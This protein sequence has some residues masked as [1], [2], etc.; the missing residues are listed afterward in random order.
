MDYK[1]KHLTELLE[2]R[3]HE[4]NG[5]TFIDEPTAGHFVSYRQLYEKASSTLFFLQTH[6][7]KPGDLL[8]FQLS[9]HLDFLSAFWACLLGKIIPAAI[10]VGPHPVSI[11]KLFK[12]WQLLPN[13]HLITFKSRLD[14]LQT[15]AEER[16]LTEIF[17][18]MKNRSI[19]IQEINESNN[20]TPGTISIPHESDPAF[21]QFSSGST[22]DPKGIILTHRNLIVNIAAII[23]GLKSPGT[24]KCFSWMP[25]SHDMGLIGFHLVPLA[26]NWDH[27]LMA[28]QLFVRNPGLWLQKISET[29]STLTV[30]PNFGY[31]YTLKHYSPA[32][33]SNLDLSC[34][35][36]I[37]NG[38]EPISPDVC[39]EFT[40]RFSRF[41]LKPQSMFPVYGLAE[42]SLAVTF[43]EPGH[44]PVFHYFKRDSLTLGKKAGE[45]GNNENED[46]I[47]LMEVGKPVNDCRVKIVDTEGSPCGELI[48][49]HILVKGDNVTP[50]Y[51][52]NETAASEAFTSDGWLKTGDLGFSRN[53]QL[54]ITGRAKEVIFIDGMSYYPNDIEWA[55]ED[56]PG[57]SFEKIAVCGVYNHYLQQD[58]VLC[59]V[60]FK[61]PLEEFLPLVTGLKD[62]MVQKIGIE[63]DHVIPV[64]HIPKTTSGKIQRHILKNDFLE[65][66]YDEVL[67]EMERLLQEQG[68][69]EAPLTF[70]EVHDRVMGSFEEVLGRSR[71]GEDENFFDL[72]GDS[73]K[74]G[75]VKLKLQKKLGRKIDDSA[76]FKFPTIHALT[77]F[78]VSNFPHSPQADSS[79]T[80]FINENNKSNKSFWK[81]GPS[82]TGS[83][84]R[85]P[86]R[87]GFID[88]N[89]D[90]T[91]NKINK[92][93]WKSSPSRRGFIE[94]NNKRFLVS[95]IAIIGMAGRF[96]GARNIKEF[97]A[98]LIAGKETVSFFSQEELKESRIDPRLIEDPRYVRAKGIIDDCEYFDAS[99]FSYS[100][101]EASIMD[102]QARVF[103]ECVWEALENAGYDPF[104]Y[105]GA[106]GLYAGASPH[107]TWALKSIPPVFDR[108]SK[109]FAEV[110]LYDK[111]FMATRISYKL[112]LKGPAFT[113]ST[114]C[115]TSLTAIHLACVGLLNNEC[116]M[117]L[118][119]GVSV[120]LPAKSGYIYE[121]GM[122]FS[123]DGHNRSFDDRASGSVFGDG[124]GV[125]LLKPLEDAIRDRDTIHAVIKGSAVNN[126]G[127]RKLGYT[128]PS[129]E[130][131]A[132]VIERALQNAGIERE[133]IGYIETHGSAT[134]LGDMVEM[135]ALTRVFGKIQDKDKTKE[136]IALGSVKT[137]VGHLNSASG[138]AGF[139]KTVL[140]LKYKKIPPSLFFETPN[141]RIDFDSIPFYVNTTLKEWKSGDESHPL[142][143]GV[144]SF[145][146][147]GTN[148]HA[149]LEAPP[150]HGEGIKRSERADTPVCPYRNIPTLTH[151]QYS[152]GANRCVRPSREFKLLVLSA[153]TRASLE[154]ASQ[155]LL[156]YLKSNPGV[157]LS[158]VAYTL[159][160]GRRHFQYRKAWVCST[161]DEAVELLSS[162]GSGKVFTFNAGERAHELHE[163]NELKEL[164]INNYQLTINNLEEKGD[165]QE[166]LNADCFAA[167]DNGKRKTENDSKLSINNYQLTINNSKR[168]EVFFLYPGI[169]A[170]YEG[171][172]A[173]LYD[174]E[175]VFREEMDR[176]IEI[177]KS[178]KGDE[179]PSEQSKLFIFEYCL[180]K[181]LFS[182]GI[183]PSMMI[184]YSFGEY[185][186][187]CISGVISLEDAL[188]LVVL[189]EQLMAGL[190]ESIMTSVPLSFDR[191]KPLV[192]G[193]LSIA[194][195][196]G[197]SC[198]VGG[199][200]E[201]VEE[202]EARMKV[203]RVMCMRV[204]VP[205]AAHSLA[206]APIL[207]LFQ[208]AVKQTRFNDPVIPYISSVTG[209]PVTRAQ[210]KS[211]SY[212]VQHLGETVRFGPALSKLLVNPNAVFVEVGPGRDLCVL[213]AGLPGYK[214]SC[215]L[216]NLAKHAGEEYDEHRYLLEKLGYLWLYGVE[217]DWPLFYANERRYRVPLPTYHF[218]KQYYPGK[219]R[220]EGDYRSE[221]A[222]L[223]DYLYIPSWKRT[224]LP[225]SIDPAQSISRGSNA[226][227]AIVL[228]NSTD[229]LDSSKSS[230][231]SKQF[232]YKNFCGV[233]GRFFQKEPL[234]YPGEKFQRVSD[235]E[236]TVNPSEVKDYEALFDELDKSGRFP[237]LII[238]LWTLD[239]G[240][241][242]EKSEEPA[243]VE[244]TLTLGFYSLIALA[245]ALG[246][247][248]LS[249]P[250]QIKVI[251]NHILDVTGGEKIDPVKAAVLGPVQVM[252]EE[253]EHIRCCLI[254]VE[255]PG[256]NRM[257]EDAWFDG[258]MAE[259][260][261]G[262]REKLVAYRNGY[263]WVQAFE[264]AEIPPVTSVTKNIS[265]KTSGAGMPAPYTYAPHYL[266]T[267]GLG[268]I[269][270][271]VAEYLAEN[272][273]AKLI[274][275]GRHAEEQIQNGEVDLN[276]LKAAGAEVM[277][278]SAD[279]SDYSQMKQAVE[280][281]EKRF[282][283]INGV[284][285]AAGVPDGVILMRRTPEMSREILAP[286]VYGTFV[287]ERLFN[288]S[289][290]DFFILF[291]SIASIL[292]PPGQAGYA[293]A[294][295]FLD[296]FTARRKL[297]SGTPIIS[298]NW[299]RWLNTGIALIAEKKHLEVSGEEMKGGIPPPVG[300]ELFGLLTAAPF[301]RVVASSVDL[302]SVFR[303]YDTS[304]GTL[305]SYVSGKAAQ[306]AVL[307][308]RPELAVEYAAP[309]T[310]MEKKIAAIWERFL[311]IDRVGL[312][313][314]FFELG[315]TSLG[316]LQAANLIKTNLEID[317]TATALY[318]YPT[319]GLLSAFLDS[320]PVSTH[321]TLNPQR[322][323]E[324][325]DEGKQK[326]KNLR[327]KSI[328]M[329]NTR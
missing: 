6:G 4:T 91:S 221:K 183:V 225:V 120:W 62:H 253:F 198:I 29:R 112:D 217:I 200:K 286:K 228:C 56:C 135:E 260:N 124:A 12:T 137:N 32:Q 251:S 35:R 319:V 230:S 92:S 316:I 289:P 271:K 41:G 187:A 326:L 155:N 311:G 240:E 72:G 255:L 75:Q 33:D 205:H 237:S 172:G 80:D 147:G 305:F 245:Q 218:E 5:I 159:H 77:D 45:T 118:A 197:P 327:S 252:A 229:S 210:V 276:R 21:I 48:T 193:G 66:K 314:N 209:E 105:P 263:R 13:P 106:I 188:R 282:G 136:Q 94:D 162:P 70:G 143:A 154:G 81:S 297:K 303:E 178:I 82:R 318:S 149:I 173:G 258:L 132:N 37:F 51:F 184:P 97:W 69:I 268:G 278:V 281:A 130:G 317:V 306:T 292:V 121:E 304:C 15:F 63:M 127:N 328:T 99:F 207:P 284:I 107:P 46:A 163:L 211:V 192:T 59:F 23:H 26:A 31:R 158:D 53:G 201:E 139:I 153:K 248:N 28:A 242:D 214:P 61:R 287:L 233:Q 266:I 71:L 169:G 129:V 257:S 108:P 79:R 231:S 199:S 103:H 273:H 202:F 294:N 2:D 144:S 290:L 145:G 43:S 49:G 235:R 109:Q 295:A 40:D 280:K 73:I 293:G 58:S 170:Q 223:T 320:N 291:S 232:L 274:L 300:L 150:P 307:H 204:N 315:A 179:T 247:R 123:A 191:L 44:E 216:V 65:G 18:H 20:I 1:Y 296:A 96:P 16:N 90:D 241:G 275:T 114:A 39:R 110:Q 101:E 10:T 85:G 236:F 74:A 152:V 14:S 203:N 141:S 181:L 194:V 239:F 19:D 182:W 119:G 244:K 34:I 262:I 219:S 186:A 196:N 256:Q 161:V 134:P 151:D 215:R 27:V 156:N 131:Q 213:A 220:D 174:S 301:Q 133:S 171:M 267:G 125:V 177:L 166:N 285:H 68:A 138:V 67:E 36:L 3:K 148:A 22:G 226:E 234:V 17:N 265:L 238:H 86:S 95:E 168:A 176:C 250:V 164:S 93:F 157:E 272:Y 254:D 299:D 25:L 288:Y 212:W 264:P 246:N 321:N 277:A 98:N 325:L 189:R 116:D 323:F 208:E 57:I 102:P 312:H 50:G 283:P 100:P 224:A 249:T 7:L 126:D 190:P 47:A 195:D 222:K 310:E 38:A 324:T 76:M 128:A 261:A 227:W 11:L 322:V 78:L 313:D 104:K 55:A 140:C 89:N 243:D 270:L 165:S 52:N 42:A 160:V 88:D 30:S 175:P 146:I 279:V 87:R 180:A 111:D 115:S 167:K 329:K 142:R 308:S 54:Y 8:V 24:D 298:I 84:R 259:L 309:G 83:S 185:A 206:M 117:A 60:V 113:V 64:L 9:H 269:G 122:I 302:R